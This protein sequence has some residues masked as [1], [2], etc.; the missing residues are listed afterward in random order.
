MSINVSSSLETSNITKN[1]SHELSYRTK[2]L[3]Q[4][5]IIWRN[6]LVLINNLL[7]W[8]HK[9]DSLIIFGI[10]T[11]IFLTST[12]E[13]KYSR[14]CER[15]A[16]LEQHIKHKCELVLKIRKERPSMYLMI[17]SICLA[18]IAFCCQNIDNLLLSYLTTLILCLTP[19]IRD[20]Q[21]I[22][23]IR[24]YI[25]GFLNNKKIV[26]SYENEEKRTQ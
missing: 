7:E 17:G 9:Y 13:A 18:F 14:L 8:E 10:I 20:R 2:E 1:E 16:N 25:D 23:L 12:K 15:I 6:V 24:Q 5:L 3:K 11:F 21:L 4:S 19:G 26:S 22:P